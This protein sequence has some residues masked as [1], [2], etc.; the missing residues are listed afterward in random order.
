MVH[1][2]RQLTE[3]LAVIEH[4]FEF[5]AVLQVVQRR[6]CFGFDFVLTAQRP[7][8]YIGSAKQSR[9][10]LSYD[11]LVNLVVGSLNTFSVPKRR[12]AL[13]MRTV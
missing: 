6:P 4:D 12:S 5:H 9:C 11:D 2:G 7:C 10:S 13:V 8:R 1:A 3:C